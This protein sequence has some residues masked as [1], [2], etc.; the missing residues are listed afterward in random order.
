MY[1]SFRPIDNLSTK[2]LFTKQLDTITPNTIL[3][4]DFDLDDVMQL[5]HD[6]PYCKL[7]GLLDKVTTQ[8]NLSKLVDLLTWPGGCSKKSNNSISKNLT[9]NGMNLLMP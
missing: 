6:Y 8:I 7:L 1:R 9:L 4:G 2:E 5:Q 3:L